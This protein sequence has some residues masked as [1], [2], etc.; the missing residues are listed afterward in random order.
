MKINIETLPFARL[1]RRFPEAV[2][3]DGTLDGHRLPFV[4]VIQWARSEGYEV[5]QDGR[6]NLAW[7]RQCAC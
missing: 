5:A 3:A 7:V 4:A 1:C 2:R 6:G